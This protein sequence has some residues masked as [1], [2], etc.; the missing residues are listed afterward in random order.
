MNTPSMLDSLRGRLVALAIVIAIAAGRLHA[1]ENSYQLKV[2]TERADAV[3]ETGQQARFL[4]TV[5]RDGQPVSEG[6]V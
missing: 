4:I 3:Y 1:A 6:K 5:T 2:V